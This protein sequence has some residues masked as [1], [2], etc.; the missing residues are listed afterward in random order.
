MG[1][2][3]SQRHEWHLRAR[4]YPGSALQAI[5][6]VFSHVQIVVMTLDVSPSSSLSLSLLHSLYLFL[7]GCSLWQI[8][9]GHAAPG[10]QH[11]SKGNLHGS[12]N[13][14]HIRGG[15]TWMI[16]GDGGMLDDGVAVLVQRRRQWL[17]CRFFFFCYLYGLAEKGIVEPRL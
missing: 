2:Q 4:A 11:G 3:S 10:G 7:A 8:M 1:D 12:K 6:I 13:N 15:G 5:I 17:G 16:Y 9:L 14:I